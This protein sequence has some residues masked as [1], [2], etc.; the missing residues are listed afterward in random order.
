MPYPM[1][2]IIGKQN[3]G[4]STLLNRAA[5]KPV[6]IVDDI[7]GT[8]R[9]RIF[10]NI[11]WHDVP[12]T[13]V[14]T[15][16][17]LPE[18]ATTLEQAVLDQGDMAIDEADLI[19]FV[20]DVKSGLTATDHEIADKL[21]KTQKPILLVVNKAD[22]EKMEQQAAEFYELGLGDPIPISAYHA[23]GTADLFDKIIA[24]LPPALV[25]ATLA[26][27][28]QPV[29]KVAIIG[30]PG[31]GK[32][33]LL[34]AIVGQPRS[35]V[36]DIPGTTRDA[37]DT[38]FDIKGESVLLIDTAGIRRR[39]H[40]AAG[41]EKY[42]VLRALRA[43]ERADVVLLVLDGSEA[44]SAQDAHIAGYVQQMA[45]GVV[46]VVNK[47][48][49]V[50]NRN[51]AQWDSDVH[52]LLKFLPYAP[53]MFSSAK[54][55]QGVDKL[56]PRAREIYQERNKRLPTSAVNDI[57]QL[58]VAE[59]GPP[60]HQNRQLR[61]FYSTQAEVNPPTFVIFVNDSRLMHFS[62]KRYLENRLRQVFG[63][64]GTPIRLVFRTRARGE[65]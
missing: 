7:P 20:V 16:G 43:I 65:A 10:A 46:L 35:L 63:F 52:T 39:G 28:K 55:G 15:A 29:M 17:I 11:T 37:V 5:G 38:M 48:D 8:T 59:H 12:F 50:E 34:N 36:N 25:E 4:K 33:L 53:V 54:T 32:S 31:V 57:I 21:R 40:I 3:V 47:W 58:A 26:E 45:K 2:A 56:I 41:V 1:V 61:V 6:A 18:P 9:D 13:L 51:P 23:R 22:N 49:L 60:K 62:Y 42:S 64:T 24:T 44:L 19:L 14:D 27:E 30:R